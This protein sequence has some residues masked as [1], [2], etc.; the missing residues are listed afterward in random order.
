MTDLSLLNDYAPVAGLQRL[1]GWLDV[2]G[3]GTFLVASEVTTAQTHASPSFPADCARE[4]LL[5]LF[6]T[7]ITACIHTHAHTPPLQMH[8]RNRRDRHESRANEHN[9]VVAASGDLFRTLSRG[10]RI[11]GLGI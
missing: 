11:G 5:D 1:A 7:T 9:I 2:T 8:Q 6:R 10:S 4:D 3:K